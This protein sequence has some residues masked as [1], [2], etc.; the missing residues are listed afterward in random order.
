MQWPLGQV[1]GLAAIIPNPSLPMR[2]SAQWIILLSRLYRPTVLGSLLGVLVAMTTRAILTR[3]PVYIVLV[4][5]DW[6][7]TFAI[8]G[9]NGL[10]VPS[11]VSVRGSKGASVAVRLVPVLDFD[12]GERIIAVIGLRA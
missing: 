5:P 7:G 10:L 2:A 11:P 1:R 12:P 8:H 6:K 9:L 4:T 3:T